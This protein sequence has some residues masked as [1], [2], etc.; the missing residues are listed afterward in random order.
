VTVSV[1]VLLSTLDTSLVL[2]DTLSGFDRIQEQIENARAA[3]HSLTS[4]DEERRSFARAE[5]RAHRAV[6]LYHM[7]LEQLRAAQ[8]AFRREF[9]SALW[10]EEDRISAAARIEAVGN[11]I[12]RRFFGWPSMRG[13]FFDGW[14]LYVLM[15]TSGKGVIESRGFEVLIYAEGVAEPEDFYMQAGWRGRRSVWR[16]RWLVL[17]RFLLRVVVLV[18]ALFAIA[19]LFLNGHPIIGSIATL[20]FLYG[21]VRGQ[22][23]EALPG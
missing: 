17:L 14:L 2:P 20:V 13:I 11:R 23:K 19:W 21:Q 15:L 18:A 9:K 12:R 1:E 5:M 4:T 16:L 6:G 22:I 10:L 7:Q 3:S 8:K